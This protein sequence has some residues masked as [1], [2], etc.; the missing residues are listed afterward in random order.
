[1]LK[2][3]TSAFDPHQTSSSRERMAADR[4]AIPIRKP[5]KWLT[6]SP[7]EKGRRVYGNSL[8][9][10]RTPWR[11]HVAKPRDKLAPSHPSVPKARARLAYSMTRVAAGLVRPHVAL[12]GP[13]SMS[14]G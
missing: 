2:A 12:L 5:S 10:E 6:P 9:P 14:A 8:R 11:S 4:L 7:R 13:P 3:K 1:M